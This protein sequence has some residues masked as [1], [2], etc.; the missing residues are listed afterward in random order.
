MLDMH[1]IGVT[2]LRFVARM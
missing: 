1:I 2:D